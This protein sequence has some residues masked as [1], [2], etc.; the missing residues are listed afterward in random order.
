MKGIG[1]LLLAIL[2]ALVSAQDLKIGAVS[3]GK[4]LSESPQAEQANKRLQ[5]EF[6]PREKAL[7]DA[8]RSLRNMEQRLSK[9]DG[10]ADAQRRKLERDV[11]A[12]RRDLQRSTE[13]FREDVN[14]RRNEELGKFQKQI[15]EVINS[16][17][18]EEGFDLIVSDGAVLFASGRVD[19][20]DKVLQ[21]LTGGRR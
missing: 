19:I 17:A 2:P 21:R 9:E 18:K 12:Q 5:S 8:Q 20:T 15:M 14:L 10:M 4:I 6:G 13:E 16:V 1:L 7:V 3:V 11:I